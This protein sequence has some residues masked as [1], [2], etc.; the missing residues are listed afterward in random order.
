VS[1]AVALLVATEAALAQTVDAPVE[2]VVI[3][4]SGVERRAFETPYAVSVVDAA[5]LRSAGPMVNLSESLNRVPG[6]VVNL[7]NNYAQDLQISS[8]GFGARS[9]FGI[10][11][12]R[13]YTDGIPATMP[14]GQGQVSHFDIAGAQRIEVLRG[15]FS[16]LYGANSGGVISLV[17]AAPRETAYT[18]DG[19]VGSNGLWQARLGVESL[20]P[21]GWNLRA[22]ASQFNT[23]GVRPHSEAQ[24]SLGNVRLGWVGDQD[25][26]TLLLNSVNQPAQDPLGLTREQFDADPY[27]TTPQAIQF[28]T[29]KTSGQTQGGGTWRHRFADTGALRESVLTLYA[30]QRDVTQWQAIPVATQA[31]PRHP[32][33]VI[34]FSRDFSGLDARLV[35]RWENAALIVGAATERQS[36]DRRGYENFT[37]SG[38]D[39]N[40][41]VTGALRRQESNS[42]RSSDLYLQGELELA[43]TVSASLGLRS[44][45]MK[46]ET[47]DEYL[48]NGNDSGSLSYS[49][50]TPVLALQWMPSPALNLYVSAGKGFESPTLNELAYR[51]DGATGF[52]TTLQPQ[53]SL[54]VELGAKWRNDA[55]GLAVEAALF[56]ADTDDEI[57]VLTNSGGRSTFQNVGS[58]RRSGAELGL[59]WQPSPAWRAMAAVTYLDATY[60][61]SFQTCRAVPCTRPADRVTVPA[62]N[63]IAGTM[64]KSGFASLAWRPVD[65]TELGFEVRAQGSMPVNDRNSDFSPSA[66]I[67]ALRLSHS[68]ALGPGT[69]TLLGR[70]DNLS[71]LAYAGAIIVNETNGRFFETAAGRTGLLAARWRQP[72]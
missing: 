23:D 34:D 66:W 8:R 15:P 2:Q 50:N 22:Q 13:L 7:R 25:T 49:Y 6:L 64:A 38:A 3:T 5:E 29:R 72:F 12:L 1:T 70:L 9:T 67:T 14:D 18:V 43:P 65:S 16:A 17:S 60:Q 47:E 55:L 45:R 51:P 10:R 21:G 62:G 35:W 52:N 57:G 26:V 53:T 19:D 69:L 33:G 42:V 32:G 30:G 27:Q 63:K 4:A 41:G 40:L 31:N 71:D 39:Q 36:E 46:V 24:R 59:R 56:R 37:G 48:A 68:I 58:T 20:L 54:Q 11:G 61:D 44:G 28:D